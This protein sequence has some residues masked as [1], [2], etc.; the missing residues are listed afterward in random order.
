VLVETPVNLT[1]K[2]KQL[3]Q[4]FKTIQEKEGNRQTPKKSTWFDGVRHF[5]D[6]LR[7]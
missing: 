4:E 5:I 1:K 6:E 2:Q 3:M 7:T